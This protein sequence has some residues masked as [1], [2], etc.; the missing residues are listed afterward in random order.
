LSNIDRNRERQAGR[1]R[2]VYVHDVELPVA[3]PA[4]D[5][6]G[7]HEPELHVGHRAVVREGHRLAGQ[8][9]VGRQSGHVPVT[10]REHRDVVA[11]LDELLG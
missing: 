6:R 4:P 1:R 9:D 2:L 8:D 7:G 11:E 5:P 3:Q 10:R